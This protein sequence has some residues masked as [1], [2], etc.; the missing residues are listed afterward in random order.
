M[1]K[2]TRFPNGVADAG[3]RR[4]N[5]RQSVTGAATVAMGLETVVGATATLETV[6]VGAGDPFVVTAK[7]SVTPGAVDIAVKQ[8]DGSAASVAAFV[9]IDAWGT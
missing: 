9:N 8:D 3:Q 5:K 2:G 6:G 1:P 7:A 4:I